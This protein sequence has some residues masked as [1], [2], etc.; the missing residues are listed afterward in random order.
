MANLFRCGGG[1]LPENLISNS[2]WIATSSDSR[3]KSPIDANNYIEVVGDIVTLHRNRSSNALVIKL[4]NLKQGKRYCFSW[5]SLTNTD[6]NLYIG[7]VTN[8][9]ATTMSSNRV[10]TTTSQYKGFFFA[11]TFGNYSMDVLLYSD[12][13]NDISIT[14]P[15]LYRIDG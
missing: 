11:N 13:I 2:V 6:N 8:E 7:Y 15:I 10:I 3:T 5:D 1:R 12:N 9:T 4:P 14:N